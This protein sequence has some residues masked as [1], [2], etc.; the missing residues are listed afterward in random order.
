MLLAVVLFHVS[1]IIEA[2]FAVLASGVQCHLAA[3]CRLELTEHHFGTQIKTV[4]SLNLAWPISTCSSC[5]LVVQEHVLF[6]FC[7]KID[8]DALAEQTDEA[9]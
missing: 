3:G 5:R 6:F 4:S 9:S 1:N 2:L 7:T 8:V